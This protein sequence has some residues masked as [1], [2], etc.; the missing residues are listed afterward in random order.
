MTPYIQ[1]SADISRRYNST[2]RWRDLAKT[3]VP[4]FC[5]WG[6]VFQNLETLKWLRDQEQTPP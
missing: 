5:R 1:D 3:W 4:P 2:K 6:V